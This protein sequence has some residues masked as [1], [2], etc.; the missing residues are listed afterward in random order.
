MTSSDKPENAADA[1]AERT[2]IAAQD[3]ATA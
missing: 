3:W 2:G 1:P